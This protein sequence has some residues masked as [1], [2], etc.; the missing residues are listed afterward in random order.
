MPSQEEYLDNL[1]KEMTNEQK[2]VSVTG[3]D[4][5]EEINIP[6]EES[7]E[8]EEP[9]KPE[10]LEEPE[11]PAEDESVSD[12]DKGMLGELTEEDIDKMLNDSRAQS[13]ENTE[14][15]SSVELS[16]D[17]LADLLAISGDDE[18]LNDIQDMLQK[19]D[20]NEA[21]D[22]DTLELLKNIS[23]ENTDAPAETKAEAKARK[24]EE[25]R[26]IKEEK[27]AAKKQA[28]EAKAAEAEAKKAVKKGM[29]DNT[30][31]EAEDI[32]EDNSDISVEMDALLNDALNE[33][34]VDNV[35]GNIDEDTVADLLADDTGSTDTEDTVSGIDDSA[36]ESAENSA[37]ES[38]ENSL[39]EKTSPK[40]GFWAKI[41][42][43][44]T[45][46]DEDEEEEKPENEDIQ[47]S[48]ENQSI[49]DEL[50]NEEE[51]SKKGKKAKKE[52]K[53][54]KDKK[55]NGD[56]K[57]GEAAEGDEDSEKDGA[58]KKDNKKGKKKEK[59]AKKDSGEQSDKKPEKRLSTKRVGLIAL[60]CLTL[61]AVILL[62]TNITGD[63]S[64]KLAGRRAFN[65]GDYQTCYQNLYGKKL[66]ESEQVMFSKS[67]CILKMRLWLREYE[68]LVEEG[69]ELEALDSLIQTVNDYPALYEYAVKW[70]SVGDITDGYSEIL[71]ILSE[72]YGVTEE[73]AKE[74][75]A[76]KNDTDYTRA[77]AQVCVD[78]GLITFDI[79]T[80]S[81]SLSEDTASETSVQEQLKDVLPEENGIVNANYIDNLNN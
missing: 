40:K 48:D 49:I 21:I 66:S 4:I 12:S 10:I 54:K 65:E 24:A 53:P 56:K 6:K 34:T 3:E 2:E 76:I 62:I 17:E 15:M 46:E 71:S 61:L 27:K 18:D 13:E 9:E 80:Q 33:E 75:A 41:L 51:K 45:K 30:P 22:E 73:Q 74:I 81:A 29:P 16:K 20:N 52:K 59:K 47:L 14:G 42:D 50:D 1:L 64:V 57:G 67:E 43:F 8:P 37:D 44:L 11:E 69:S 60:V 25:K 32:P 70:N 38:A 5:P 72:K 19:S 68:M 28:K 63:Y 79:L 31:K 23:A 39:T 77:V 58:D 35:V 55:S 7:E 26:R 78:K 36:D